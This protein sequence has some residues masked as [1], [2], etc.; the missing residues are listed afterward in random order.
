MSQLTFEPLVA[1]ALWACLALLSGLALAW[2][3]LRRPASVSSRR[4]TLIMTLMTAG[5]AAVLLVLL[6]PTWLVPIPPAAGKPGLTL[7]LDRSAS[8][9][10]GD[11]E[12]GTS[13]YRAA[14]EVAASMA[15]QLGARFD[16]RLRV[17]SDRSSAA[18]PGG[19]SSIRPDGQA[20]DLARTLTECLDEDRPQGQAIVLL[21]DGID[22]ALGGAGA[23]LR[24]V[25]IAKAMAAPIYT[26][27]FGGKGSL[28][29]LEI[30]LARQQEL[31]SVGQ[32]VPL[33]A[34]LRQRGALAANAVVSLTQGNQ[35]IERQTVALAADGT[36]T[37][38]FLASQDESGLFRYE[39]RVQ[40][41]PGEVT[42]ANNR[43]TFLLRVV[44]EPVPLLVLEGKPYWD[45]KFLVR[46]L[47]A[48]RSLK[49]DAVVRL[50]DSR[51]IRRTLR[52]P[53]TMESS[54]AENGGAP[55]EAAPAPRLETVQVLNDPATL[56]DEQG[57]SGWQVVVLGRDAE[58]FL[59]ESMIARL[60][61]WISRDGGSLV[62]YR[63]SPVARMNQDL[64]RLMPVR[65]SPASES[66][67]RIQLTGRGKELHWFATLG[68][69]GG[70]VLGKL[71]SLASVA[72]PER[73]G[74]LAV[75]LAQA[76]TEES[77]P[78]VT[79][80]PY[81]TGRVVTLEGAGMWR[82]AFLPPEFRNQ[83]AVYDALWQSLVRW[84]VSGV[85][86]VPGQN[87]A[88]SV[89]KVS[90]LTGEPAA[91][92]LLIRESAIA[93]DLPAVELA[94]G[95]G[96]AAGTFTPSPL[97]D[98]PGVYRVSFGVLPQGQYRASVAGSD[99]PNASA[100]VA[101][102]VQ[103]YTGEQLDL[104]ARPDLMA[105]IAA[106]SGGAVLDDAPAAITAHFQQFLSRSHPERVVRQA[107]WDRWWVL[108]GVF[109]VW[110]AAWSFRRMQGLI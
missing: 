6:N 27:T 11:A 105:R 39:L 9:A 50:T 96:T 30:S 108:L 98:E 52:W 86:L 85:G 18:E 97:G 53:D 64:A 41:L 12:N 70:D 82:W 51:F 101:F 75:V 1:P 36:A 20:T 93:K 7:L 68:D 46:T 37:V 90:F 55:S 28:R 74:P 76:E 13:R 33:T 5:Q 48:D 10:T 60:R 106:E 102:D 34:V 99:Q 91:A 100:N 24:A 35:E 42:E 95:D 31:A 40:P 84:L 47:A 59:D 54:N 103:S 21:S 43:A 16:V 38:R 78:L 65:W 72:R 104:T 69:P 23:V 94:R 71:P 15:G 8:M 58:A 88:L 26:R 19:L 63:G 22:N 56:F 2:Y 110:T 49:L 57:L 79:W 107:A 77:P 62:C 25:Q 17:F 92:T 67:F 14:A 89:D 44:K 3:G 109:A 66:R 29:D 45:G 87:V 73:P 83:E 61:T 81:G 4:W 80:Q 32:K